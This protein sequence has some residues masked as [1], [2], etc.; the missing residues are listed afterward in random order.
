M[1]CNHTSLCIPFLCAFLSEHTPFPILRVKEVVVRGRR[2]DEGQRPVP[3]STRPELMITSRGAQPSCCISRVAQ[4]QQLPLQLESSASI[5]SIR[6]RLSARGKKSHAIH[7]G[8]LPLPQRNRCIVRNRG[9]NLDSRSELSISLLGAQLKKRF[10]L[11]DLS[12]RWF[13]RPQTE[14]ALHGYNKMSTTLTKKAKN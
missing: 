4:G 11:E 10:G 2:K 14:I 5:M 1:L 6:E 7:E 12:S 8:K 9:P 3:P 13:W